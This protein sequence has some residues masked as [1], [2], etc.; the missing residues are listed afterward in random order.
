MMEDKSK[1]YSLLIEEVGQVIEERAGLSPLAARIYTTLILASEEGLNFEEITILHHASKSSVSNNLNVLVKLD[2][3]EY[4]TKPGERKKFFRSSPNYAVNAMKKYEELFAK[5]TSIIS[6]IN[7]F[8][9]E[10][11]AEKFNNQKIAG[12]LY[13]DFLS[14]ITWEFKNKIREFERLSNP[15]KS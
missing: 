12:P 11:N 7:T 9:K 13:H 1:E 3:V 8:N 5:E 15:A 2:Y 4:Y 10:H 14:K 6:K